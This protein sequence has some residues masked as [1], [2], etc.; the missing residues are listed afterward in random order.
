[1][2][3][4]KID[5]VNEALFIGCNHL[6]GFGITEE[7]RN[8]PVIVSPTP[9]LTQYNSPRNRVLVCAKRDANPFFH[10][11]E[12][13]W[14]L[15]G[16]N[17]LAFCKKFVSTFDKFS[18]DGETLHGAY[19]YRWRNWFTHDQ[20]E[21]IIA[22]LRKDPTTRRAV[23]AM[24]D[25]NVDPATADNGGKDVPCNTHIYFDTLGGVLN[26]TICCRS[27]DM[28]LG[29]YGANAVHFSVLLEYMAVATQIPMGVMR[30]FSNN[31]HAYTELY[32]QVTG[33]ASMLQLGA[34]ALREDFYGAPGPL[35][36]RVYTGPDVFTPAPLVQESESA[37][38][39]MADAEAFCDGFDQVVFATKFFRDVAAPM[40]S[41]W[42]AWK[43]GSYERADH[44]ALRIYAD[45]WRAAAQS[46]LS[47]RKRRRT[48]KA[49]G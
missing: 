45:D 24:W 4:I 25:A 3:V 48:E 29:A 21:H 39:F 27:N 42:E 11:F 23:L 22:T 13:M 49:N 7:S 18:D 10:L 26:M 40:Y 37:E 44:L 38:Q 19:G 1:M 46:W 35:Q 9:V 43:T 2:R 16:R 41:A 28:V 5:S 31:Y 47:I 36:S 12:A 33:R 30:Q 17:D 6:A 14:M 34:E 20:L 8:G 32:P 15:A